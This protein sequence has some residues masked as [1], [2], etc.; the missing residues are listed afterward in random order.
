MEYEQSCGPKN[1]QKGR[2]LTWQKPQEGTGIFR[3]VARGGRGRGR[4]W[5]AR[6]LS[7]LE[8]YVNVRLVLHHSLTRCSC[9]MIWFETELHRRCRKLVFFSKL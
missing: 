5:G 6:A 4:G 7:S 9:K 2:Q 3:G 1:Q 8:V